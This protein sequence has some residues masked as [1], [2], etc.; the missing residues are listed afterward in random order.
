[1]A[2]FK[3]IKNGN[4]ITNDKIHQMVQYLIQRRLQLD[5]ATKETY[6]YRHISCLLCGVSRKQYQRAG[7]HRRKLY[8][9]VV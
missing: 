7:N 2:T 8:A 4:E 1:M 3:L 9:R 6:P 5:K